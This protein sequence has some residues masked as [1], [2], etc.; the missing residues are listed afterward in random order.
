MGRVIRVDEDQLE[1]IYDDDGTFRGH[2]F[3]AGA[4]QGAPR[5]KTAKLSHPWLIVFLPGLRRLARLDGDLTLTDIRI[6]LEM[7]H[8]SPADGGEWEINS[9]EVCKELGLYPSRLSAAIT[10]LD[11]AG[12]LIRTRRGHVSFAPLV[13]W[14]GSSATREELLNPAEE[15]EQLP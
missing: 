14:R 3:P 12:Y 15:R 11:K 9:A 8:R 2:A 7:F 10:K 4:V 6:L 1:R 13:A 5:Q